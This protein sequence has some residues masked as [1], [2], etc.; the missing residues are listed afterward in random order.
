MLTPGI[1]R[2]SSAKLADGAV[3][4]ASDVITLIVGTRV[5]QLLLALRPGDDDGLVVLGRFVGL[6]RF[7]GFC[8][9]AGG[10]AW[11]GGG[12]A[13]VAPAKPARPAHGRTT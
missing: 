6:R 2:S 13:G 8:V 12:V 4:I 10:G 7:V 9:A 1:V 5:D 3:S 11:A